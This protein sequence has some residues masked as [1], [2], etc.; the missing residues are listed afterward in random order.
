MESEARMVNRIIL[1][2]D[3]L[4]GMGG[5]KKVYRH[6]DDPALCIKI[7]IAGEQDPDWQKEMYYRRSRQRR[8]L[9]SRLM[10]AYHGDVDTNM[11]IGRVFERVVDYDGSASLT[12]DEWID[13]HDDELRLDA[14]PAV[15]LLM[16]LR[17]AMLDEEIVTYNMQ[18]GNFMVQ[19]VSECELR[20][21]VIDNLGSASHL[22]IAFFFTSI[23]RKHIKKY[24]A[25]FTR[26]L[27]KIYPEIFDEEKIARLENFDAHKIST[28]ELVTI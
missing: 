19:R 12:L 4:I 6:P 15:S 26:D 22:P 18:A 16:K 10:T 23:A 24:W 27:L 8:H 14:S 3:M 28:S 7:L 2:D 5:H 1:S 11:G 17:D 13:A 25:R 9:T 20:P 21:R